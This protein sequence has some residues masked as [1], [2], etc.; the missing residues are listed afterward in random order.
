MLGL[1]AA[2][3]CSLLGG[4]PPTGGAPHRSPRRGPGCRCGRPMAAL[5]S[6]QSSVSSVRVRG[7]CNAAAGLHLA[8]TSASSLVFSTHL[9]NYTGV[10]NTDRCHEAYLYAFLSVILI[11]THIIFFSYL[12]H[13]LCF[14]FS[15]YIIYM[16]HTLHIYYNN[17]TLY[18][19]LSHSCPPCVA[20]RVWP[21]W[22]GYGDL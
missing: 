16:V 20:E 1:T 3:H 14:A 13:V 6:L 15:K 9:C 19:H 18:L 17:P 8:S 22:C 12:V 5:S 21:V 11:C 2:A 4:C 10:N 7:D